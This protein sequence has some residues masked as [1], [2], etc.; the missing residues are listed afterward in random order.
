MHPVKPPPNKAEVV[1]TLVASGFVLR[2]SETRTNY[3]AALAERTDLLGIQVRY[4]VAIAACRLNAAD[5]TSL[6]RTA[7]REHAGL[8]IVGTVEQAPADASVLTYEQF[9]DRLGGSIFSMLPFEP[10]YGQ[11]LVTLGHNLLPD[12]LQGAPDDLFEQY[13]HAGLQFLFRSRVLRYGQERRGEEVPDG[14]ALASAAPLLLYDAKAAK[15]GYRMSSTAE[16][17]FSDYVVSFHR[18][19][20]RLVGRLTAFLAISGSFADSA[21]S[22]ERRSRKV[23]ADCGV[24]LSFMDAETL[25]EIVGMLVQEP[26]FRQA[27]DWRLVF[28]APRVRAEIVRNELDATRRDRVVEVHG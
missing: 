11:R 21:N 20:E 2:G 8:V 25:A 7:Q 1:R 13:V 5:V 27:L 9:A 18:D 4:L 19:Y 12:D 3:F 24:Q 17:Q 10:E 16:R 26:I 22:L 14:V 23:F 15:D 6:S 28:A